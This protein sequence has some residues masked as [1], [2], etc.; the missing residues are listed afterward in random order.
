VSSRAPA[1]PFGNSIRRL[2]MGRALGRLTDSV[3]FGALSG[4]LLEE[5]PDPA[6]P[7]HDWARLEVLLCGVCDSDINRAPRGTRGTAQAPD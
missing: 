6:L 2:L 7:G 3:V 4:L 5:V 1:L